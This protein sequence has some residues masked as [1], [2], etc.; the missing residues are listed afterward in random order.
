MQERF[1]RSR[2]LL[3]E[4]SMD[5]LRKTSIAVVGLGG[6][7]GYAFESMVRIGIGLIKIVDPDRVDLSNINRQISALTSTIGQYKTDVL[8]SRAK[9][10]NPDII[11]RKY[12]FEYNVG[13]SQE[14]LSDV[15]YVIDCIDSMEDKIHLIRSCM[16]KDIPLISSMGA[17]NR[18]DP[19]S[20]QIADIKDTRVCPMAKKVRKKL[21]E[22]GIDSGLKVVYSY[23]NPV[24]VE[25]NPYT[26]LGSVS[27]VP[28]A[29]GLLLAS[30]VVKDILK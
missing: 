26:R 2:L 14:I 3:G 1:L 18:L 23:E 5:R 4:D 29:A 20:L 27:F 11:I 25:E 6:V 21:R 28:P 9:D 13:S 17:A 7:G 16:E 22:F 12:S 10:I 8:E 19:A 24:K 30:E 15:D